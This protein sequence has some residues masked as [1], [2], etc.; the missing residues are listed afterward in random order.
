M[1]AGLSTFCATTLSAQQYNLVMDRFQYNLIDREVNTPGANFHTAFRPYRLADIRQVT[2]PDTA[3][4]IPDPGGKFAGTWVGRKLFRENFLRLDSSEYQVYADPLFSFDG[5]KDQLT[6]VTTYTNSRGLQ[7]FGNLGKKVSFYTAFWE[8]QARFVNYVDSFV[9]RQNVVPGQGRIKP[10]GTGGY[11]YAWASGSIS[12][13]PSKIF[14]F[15]AG[16][17]KQFIGDGYRSLML[18]DNAFNFPYLKITTTFWKIRYTNLFT[19]FQNVG[20]AANTGLGGYQKKYASFHHLSWNFGKRFNVGLFE[21][22]VWQSVD[23]AGQRRNFDVNYLNPV[24]FYRPVEFSLGSPDNALLGFNMKFIFMK[25]NVLYGQVMLD[26]F[27][28]KEVRARSGWWG[29]K[30]GFQAGL[31]IFNL[32]GLKTLAIQ[33]EFNY[34]RPYTYGHYT[35][36]QS[37]THFAQPLA[38]PLGA[39]FMESVNFIRYR[40]RRIGVEG[41]LLAAQYG[42][43]TRDN[44]GNWSNWGQNIFVATAETFNQPTSVPNIYGNKTLQ[45]LKNTVIF[46]DL[47]VSYLINRRT[48]MRVELNLSRRMQ[49]NEL[50]RQNT[51]WVFF[52]FRTALPNRYYDF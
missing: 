52:S 29:N 21:S 24:I 19:A 22:I 20:S 45:G 14:N 44:N 50:V 27:S 17:D 6:D 7:V 28:L 13:S 25:N 23:T 39:N 42:A 33:S 35:A 37:Y 41:K 3:A 40:W 8:N 12:Y 34:V 31:K 10:F 5:G 36:T 15:Q 30:Q 4:G 43:D 11:D 48:N 47:T 16:N 49:H 9:T 51:N 46:T 1:L 2:D 26:E 38:H 18:S 32:F